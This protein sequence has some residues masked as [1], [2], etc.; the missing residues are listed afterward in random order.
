MLLVLV[1]NGCKNL[2]IFTEN[3]SLDTVNF[4]LTNSIQLKN[5]LAFALFSDGFNASS[6][7]PGDSKLWTELRTAT[8]FS[9]N[10]EI[11]RSRRQIG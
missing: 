9:S 5:N 10:E 6:S 4:K 3:R 8:R 11:R 2:L 7:T 1:L